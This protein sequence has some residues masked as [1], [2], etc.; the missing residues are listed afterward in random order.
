MRSVAFRESCVAAACA[1]LLWFVGFEPSWAQ[2]KDEHLFVSGTDL[3]T[4]LFGSLDAG[5]SSFITLGA[6]QT[7][8]GPLARSGFVS[9]AAV[10]YGGPPRG[11]ISR[12]IRTLSCGPRCRPAR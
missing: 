4:V 9:L 5:R 12:R 2:A 3:K 8:S 7:L 11:P 1:A 10:G 6:K